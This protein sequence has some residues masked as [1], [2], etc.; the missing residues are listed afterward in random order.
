MV[1]EVTM[2]AIGSSIANLLSHP[3]HVRVRTGNDVDG[4]DFADAAGGFGAGI[5]R[6]ANRGDVT[7]EGDGDQAAADL[8]LFDEGD[9]RGL[10]CRVA[11]LDGRDDALGFD[12]SDC[13][14]V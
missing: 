9:I 2:P 1:T 11:R 12:Q 10:E 6:G 5:H 7:L 14:T 13:F 8:V 4:D 3:R